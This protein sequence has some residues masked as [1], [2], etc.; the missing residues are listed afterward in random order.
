[1]EEYQ[2][3]ITE[4]T[5]NLTEYIPKSKEYYAKL[6]EF[7]GPLDILLHFVKEEELNL[8]DIPISKITKDFIGYIE[9]IQELD[10]EVAG[11]F[12]LMAAE[13]MKIKARMLIP[14]EIAEDSNKEEDPRYLLVKQLL[15]YK[16]FKDVSDEL[17]ILEQDAKMI[18]PRGYIDSDPKEFD[19]DIMFDKS[20][21]NLTILNL[22]KGYRNAV[23]GFKPAVVHPIE[24]L[25]ITTE[26]QRDYIFNQLQTVQEIDFDLLVSDMK[27]KLEVICTFL[28]LLQL[29]LDR[30]IE[31]IV[32]KEDYSKFRIRKKSL[33]PALI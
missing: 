27:E 17:L 20:L 13:L 23:I 1:M 4:N 32:D 8:Y 6:P 25:D 26:I 19:S 30:Y 2:S 3:I 12:L 15:E 16:R 14:Q 18:Y 9:Y 29:A 33:L 7:E 31:L 21:K 28:C 22:I 10:I 11:E 24:I 5:S